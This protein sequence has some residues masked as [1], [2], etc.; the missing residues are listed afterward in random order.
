M[1]GVC[2]FHYL[3]FTLSHPSGELFAGGG[4]IFSSGA[5]HL[6]GKVPQ[7]GATEASHRE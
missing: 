3:L 5:P 2:Y 7:A 4:D 1:C 6:V